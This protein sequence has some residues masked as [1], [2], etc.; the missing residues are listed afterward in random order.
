MYFIIKWPDRCSIQQLK[1]CSSFNPSCSVMEHWTIGVRLVLRFLS[2][3]YLLLTIL[4]PIK[5]KWKRLSYQILA[6]ILFS[7]WFS[8]DLLY[9][10]DC[11]SMPGHLF[12]KPLKRTTDKGKCQ[13][14]TRPQIPT[15]STRQRTWTNA[16]VGN[17]AS[18]QNSEGTR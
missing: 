10:A 9:H 5:S 6:W 4:A 12:N 17:N 7:R 8:P 1:V 15:E 11:T 16:R 3:V 13:I 2:N 14:N 18:L